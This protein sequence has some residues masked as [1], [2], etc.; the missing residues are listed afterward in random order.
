VAVPLTEGLGR[1][2]VPDETMREVSYGDGDLPWSG[3]ISRDDCPWGVVLSLKIAKAIQGR[4][5][6]RI[7][8]K[9]PRMG[10]MGHSGTAASNTPKARLGANQAKKAMKHHSRR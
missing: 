5:N 3:E 9:G 1:W 4:M 2:V 10:R 6:S 8:T 7:T